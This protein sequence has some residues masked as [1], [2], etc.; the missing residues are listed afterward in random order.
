MK[1]MKKLPEDR[2]CGI[3][4]ALQA[5]GAITPVEAMA[6]I[7]CAETLRE[8]RAAVMQAARDRIALRATDEDHPVG[9]NAGR[10]P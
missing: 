3:V 5:R 1:D 10:K 2:A 6:L 8:L 4:N 7:E 9:P